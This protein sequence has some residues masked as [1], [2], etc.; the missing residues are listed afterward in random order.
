MIWERGSLVL[1]GSV[2][3]LLCHHIMPDT[4]EKNLAKLW[5]TVQTLYR[6]LEVVLCAVLCI[7]HYAL[8]CLSS[9]IK[10]PWV[11][12]CV[13]GSKGE[14]IWH[15]EADNVQAGRHDETSRQS[16]GNSRIWK[17]AV[18]PFWDAFQSAF[19]GASENSTLSSA[20]GKD[21]DDIGWAPWRL[22]FAG[23]ACFCVRV[24]VCVLIELSYG[25]LTVSC[26]CV[27]CGLLYVK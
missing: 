10:L 22:C 27:L 6:S 25:F 8:P 1:F 23:C 26:I 21:G 19:G 14:Q 7:L 20:W 9:Y 17:S 11:V 5:S 24:F 3:H 2:M 13:G 18:S 4:P 15:D 16:R 12:L